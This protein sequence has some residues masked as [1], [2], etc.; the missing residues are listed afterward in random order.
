[1]STY[2]TH[3]RIE[4][5]C[6]KCSPMD[7]A[8]GLTEAEEDAADLAYIKAA[9]G[10]GYGKTIP[11][12]QVKAEL[13]LNEGVKHDDGKAPLWWV[14]KESLE[15]VATIMEFGAKK[16]KAHNWRKGM[17]WTRLASAALRHLTSWCNGENTDPESGRSHLWHAACCIAFLIVYE[18]QGLGEDDRGFEP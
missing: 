13:G 14:P 2:C 3:N 7:G 8:T 12:E 11:W 4:W 9:N 16:Y 17:K 6:L 10:G 5:A 1:M 15:A 18:V